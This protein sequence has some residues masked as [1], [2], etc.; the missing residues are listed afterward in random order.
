MVQINLSAF[1]VA[2][3][4]AGIGSHKDQLSPEWSDPP[5]HI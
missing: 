3:A 4:L 2:D 1:A 5:D